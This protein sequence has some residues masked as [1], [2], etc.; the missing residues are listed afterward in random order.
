V[1]GNSWTASTAYTL[2]MSSADR[3]IAASRMRSRTSSAPDER[4]AFPGVRLLPDPQFVQF[5][6]E[7]GPVDGRP[8]EVC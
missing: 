1:K 5:G 4:V 3:A 7:G 2:L 8:A 6:L